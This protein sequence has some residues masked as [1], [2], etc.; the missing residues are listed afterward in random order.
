MVNTELFTG[1]TGLITKSKNKYIIRE[2]GKGI[3]Q[4]WIFVEITS[5]SILILPVILEKENLVKMH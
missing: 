4:V 3:D 1:Q 5:L 2:N